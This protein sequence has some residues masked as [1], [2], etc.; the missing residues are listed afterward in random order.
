VRTSSRSALRAPAQAQRGV[1]RGG[2]PAPLTR[3][4]GQLGPARA[5]ALDRSA[6]TRGSARASAVH[7]R[8]YPSEGSEQLGSACLP[9]P[10]SL[11]PGPAAS[12]DALSWTRAALS[13][14]ILHPPPPWPGAGAPRPRR[15]RRCS[16]AVGW[17]AAHHYPAPICIAPGRNARGACPNRAP[18][19]PAPPGRA[20]GRPAPDGLQLAIDLLEVHAAQAPR[21]RTAPRRGQPH[22][23]LRRHRGRHRLVPQRGRRGA[24]P[25]R[26]RPRRAAA[27]RHQAGGPRA[28][29]R[30]GAGRGVAGRKR[31]GVLEPERVQQ[32]ARRGRAARA[33][34]P[35]HRQRERGV[36]VA[37][38]LRARPPNSGCSRSVEC[39][40]PVF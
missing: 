30:P 7:A 26:G 32:R 3:G 40:S 17:P 36:H 38:I 15:S 5:W 6:D 21:A 25:A 22:E 24:R 8:Q 31:P 19:A 10:A 34:V 16:P 2:A 37:H 35:M 14:R 12:L 11:P 20:G 9:P 4:R 1:G 28:R 27:A 18:T 13:D 29:R 33:P 23:R 39:T